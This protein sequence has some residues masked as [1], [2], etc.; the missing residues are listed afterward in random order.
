MRRYT[1]G[2]IFYDTKWEAGVASGFKMWI[3]H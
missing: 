3:V 1:A 2:I